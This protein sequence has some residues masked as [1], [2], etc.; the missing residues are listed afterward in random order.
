MVDMTRRLHIVCYDIRCPKRWRRVFALMKRSGKHRQLSV[1]LVH[2]N[3]AGVER[4]VHW[5]EKIIDPDEDTVL[6]APVGN[7]GQMIELGVSSEPPGA[8]LLII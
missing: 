4:L 5:L 6:I 1:F 8:K 2:A 7:G 3:R